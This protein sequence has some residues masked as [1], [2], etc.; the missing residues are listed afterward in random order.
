MITQAI[1]VSQKLINGQ[2][3]ATYVSASVA[4]EITGIS[5]KEINA[6]IR[7]DLDSAG[8]FIWTRPD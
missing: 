2:W 4:Q 8:G 6:C 7:R 5:R 1:P 3:L